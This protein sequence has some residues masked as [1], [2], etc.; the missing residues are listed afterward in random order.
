MNLKLVELLT[1]QR[2]ESV[3]LA[4]PAPIFVVRRQYATWVLS[5]SLSR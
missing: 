2:A 3:N 4:L 5:K 1:V